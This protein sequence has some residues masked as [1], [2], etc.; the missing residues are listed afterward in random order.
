MRRSLFALMALLSLTGPPAA[1]DDVLI[2]TPAAT[3]SATVALPEARTGRVPTLLVFDIYSDP[4]AL[5]AQAEEFAARGYAGVVADVRGKRLSPD[6]IVP[7]EHDA[8]DTRAVLDWIVKQPW[9]DGR[10]GMI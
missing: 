4:K 7:Y 5:Q 9:S 8:E 3:L 6:P 1:A 10:V 2:K